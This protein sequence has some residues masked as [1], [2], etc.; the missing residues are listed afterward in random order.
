M[1]HLLKIKKCYADAI[2]EG[3]KNFEVRLNDRGYNAGDIIYF[4]HVCG[5]DE[6]Y[7][8]AHDIMNRPFKITY[9]YSGLG[10]EPNYV[11]FGIKE[12][13]EDSEILK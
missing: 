5:N 2:I 4:N 11:V 1:I 3:R 6:G 7:C 12:V 8:P 9:I 13:Q 10:V